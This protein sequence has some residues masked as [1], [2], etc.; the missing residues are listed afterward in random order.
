[1]AKTQKKSK[2]PVKSKRAA[3]PGTRWWTTS[4]A[5]GSKYAANGNT[6][7]SVMRSR[8]A[9]RSRASRARTA[10]AVLDWLG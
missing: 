7:R 4:K 9:C 6:L 10:A 2:P 3:A 5:A 1:M 8:P